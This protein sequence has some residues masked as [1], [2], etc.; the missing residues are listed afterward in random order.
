MHMESIFIAEATIPEQKKWKAFW[1]DIKVA[2]L[3]TVKN[4][5]VIGWYVYTG[6]GFILP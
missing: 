2:Q 3:A 4:D 5:L 6:P 1:I